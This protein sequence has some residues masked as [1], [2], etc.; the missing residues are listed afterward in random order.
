MTWLCGFQHRKGILEWRTF[1]SWLPGHLGI[2]IQSPNTQCSKANSESGTKWTAEVLDTYLT[3]PKKFMPGTK[4]AFAGL[5][6]DKDRADII[7]FL[8]TLA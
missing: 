3:N 1:R 8:E 7:S 6:K 4:M 2:Q 5:K